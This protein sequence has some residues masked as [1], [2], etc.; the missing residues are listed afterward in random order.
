[1]TWLVILLY[2]LA[3]VLPIVGLSRT[4]LSAFASEKPDPDAE[5]DFDTYVNQFGKRVR[6]SGKNQA[7]VD[8]CLVGLGLACGAWA[9][10]WSLFL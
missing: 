4:L 7:I 5:L 1:M 10:I 9:S 3:A 6:R 8:L 2:I